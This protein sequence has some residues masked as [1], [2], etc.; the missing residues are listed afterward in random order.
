MITW[1]GAVIIATMFSQHWWISWKA[2]RASWTEIL[3]FYRWI[4]RYAVFVPI[5]LAVVGFLVLIMDEFSKSPR[6]FVSSVHAF[7]ND[8]SGPVSVLFIAFFAG[9]LR[10]FA[11]RAIG[12]NEKILGSAKDLCRSFFDHKR[13]SMESSIGRISGG[14]LGQRHDAWFAWMCLSLAVTL[15]NAVWETWLN[16]AAPALE[17]SP[18]LNGEHHVN[19]TNLAVALGAVLYVVVGY[20]LWIY[21]VLFAKLT[22]DHH[23]TS[24]AARLFLGRLFGDQVPIQSVIIG[25][26]HAGKTF[27]CNQVAPNATSGPASD[28]KRDRTATIDIRNGAATLPTEAGEVTYQLSTLDTPGE[29]MG[30][31]ILLASIFRSDVLVFVLDRGMFDVESLEDERNYAV[32]GWHNLIIDG[33]SEAIRQTSA[34]MQGFHLATMRSVG[35]L[36]ESEQLFKV[37]S[38]V[39]YLNQKP[40]DYHMDQEARDD[41]V[42]E[43]IMEHLKRVDEGLDRHQKQ[44]Q[45]LAQEI[46]RR[47]GVP[48]E[49]CCCI[50]GNAS[51]QHGA[52][53]LPRS[54][55]DRLMRSQWPQNSQKAA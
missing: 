44:W 55:E 36:I 41:R 1:I 30:D 38:F 45:Q 2:E 42:P 28:S 34:Y 32:Q 14:V 52:H 49:K 35:G 16:N 53:L 39:L 18:S 6:G 46:G 10:L 40:T 21:M 20:F 24:R 50:G 33:E 37:K 48:R 7:I 17:A 31:H 43:N 15:F 19:Y 29:N 11:E 51:A 23:L 9:V 12:A 54:T 8:N 5:L 22:Q 27:F 26:P 4:M 13:L 47:F 3:N 25:P